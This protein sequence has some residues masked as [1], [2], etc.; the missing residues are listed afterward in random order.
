MLTSDIFGLQALRWSKAFGLVKSHYESIAVS[1]LRALNL[2]ALKTFRDHIHFF[3][4]P[5]T[6]PAILG[7]TFGHN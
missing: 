4:V 5:S 6:G 3:V 7:L 1:I 2:F